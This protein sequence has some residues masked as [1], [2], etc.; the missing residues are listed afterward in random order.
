MVYV[1]LVCWQLASRN[2]PDPARQLSA[3]LLWHIPLLCVQWKTHDDGQRNCPKHVVF[4]SKNKFEKLVHLVGFIIRIYHN[5][6]SPECQIHNFPVAIIIVAGPLRDSAWNFTRLCFIHIL[7]TANYSRLTG[8]F[9]SSH[10][11]Q[12]GHAVAQL[13][14]ALCYKPEGRGFNSRW[15]HWNFSLSRSFWP[16]CGPKVDSASNRNEYQEYFLG[17]KAAGA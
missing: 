6:R 12:K 5:A 8:N 10:I 16:H 3:N 15:R 2:R 4:Y 13:V 11:Y 14:E 17:L 1:I 9:L 7:F